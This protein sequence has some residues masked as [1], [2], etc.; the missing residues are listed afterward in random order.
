MAISILLSGLF[1]RKTLN[2]SLITSL[3]Q[4][5]NERV[6]ELET[7]IEK[8]NKII[9]NQTAGGVNPS[10]NSNKIRGELTLQYIKKQDRMIR[11]LESNYPKSPQIS[12]RPLRIYSVKLLT[13]IWISEPPLNLECR[14]P[15]GWVVGYIYSMKSNISHMGYFPYGIQKMEKLDAFYPRDKQRIFVNRRRELKLLELVK[16]SMESGIRKHIAFIGLRRI[17]K[18]M[19]CLEFMKR[20]LREMPSVYIDFKKFSFVPELF[21]K[22]YMGYIVYWLFGEG[23]DPQKYTDIKVQ[24]DTLSEKMPSLV[25]YITSLQAELEKEAPDRVACISKAFNFPEIVAK[26]LNKPVMMFLDE[27]QEMME[28]DNYREIK[29]VVDKFRSFLQSQ[30]RIVYVISGSA[31]STMEYICSDAKSA[32][33]AHLREDHISN[34]TREDAG[35]LTKKILMQHSMDV[36]PEIHSRIYKLT[37]GHPFYITALTERVIEMVK[38][39]DLSLNEELV[40]R[41]FVLELTA[42]NSRIY[43]FCNYIF[44]ESIERARGSNL[45]KAIL[46]TISEGDLS[47]TQISKRLKR[48]TGVIRNALRQLMEVDLVVHEGRLYGFR[49]PILM[50]WV[51]F[52]Y[53]GIELGDDIKSGVLD[54][55]VKELEE[56]YL[57]ASS[58][59]GIAKEYEFKVKLEDEF[60]MRLNNYRSGDGEIEFDLLGE[61]NGIWHIFEIKWR[62]KLA[63]YKDMKDFL[64]KIKASEFSSKPKKLFFI[65]KTG[66]TEKALEFARKNDISLSGSDLKFRHR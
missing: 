51:G 20:N 37:R 22:Y 17:G 54:K 44:N 48:K 43:S 30:S 25:P 56:K 61:K 19:V 13:L 34:F 2:A 4:R 52:F 60:K 32:L 24:I 12:T 5:Q 10:P 57:R 64:E 59:L 39:Y 15:C 65:S 8:Q 9:K 66:F 47:L 38:L 11:E 40:D 3:I 41:C 7:M 29:P 58:E 27:F 46:Q 21:V 45:L 14:D 53:R 6:R 33:F 62:N 42:P 36:A 1:S 26:E 50:H 35:V 18:S 23:I 16:T 63:S 55:L 49:D 28:M 31:V